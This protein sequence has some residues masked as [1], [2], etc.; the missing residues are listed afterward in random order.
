MAWTR[1]FIIFVKRCMLIYKNGN[2]I[3]ENF[4]RYLQQNIDFAGFSRC[5]WIFLCR[6]YVLFL[7]SWQSYCFSFVTLKLCLHKINN[8]AIKSLK[9]K[10]KIYVAWQK[11]SFTSFRW[12][13]FILPSQNFYKS[14]S[15]NKNSLTSYSCFILWFFSHS[16]K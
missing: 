13:Y 6:E 10:R 1:H 4:F 11:I 12:V 16:W 9:F 15:S 5:H 8:Y 14:Q 3:T 7:P 2:W